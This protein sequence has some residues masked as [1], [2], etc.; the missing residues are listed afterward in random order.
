MIEQ[1]MQIDWLTTEADVLALEEAWDELLADSVMDTIFLSHAWAMCWWRHFGAG[2]TL[3]VLTVRDTDGRL[4]GLAP[5]VMGRGGWLGIWPARQLSL[6]GAEPTFADHLDVILRRGY[7]DS[8]GRALW[9]SLTNGD[10]TWDLMRIDGFSAASPMHALWGERAVSLSV[11]ACH[12]LTL[13]ATWTDYLDTLPAS[14][15]QRLGKRRRRLMK[16]DPEGAAFRT[17][18]QPDDLAPALE[19]LFRL[20]QENQQ[21]RGNAGSFAD[22]STRAF[23]H[24]VARRFLEKGW[25]RL[26]VITVG[27]EDIATAYC[28]QKNGTVSFFST[29]FSH[30]FTHHNPGRQILAHA[31]EKAIEDQATT[32][33]FLRGDESY[34]DSYSSTVRT[35]VHLCVAGHARARLLLGVQA[36]YKAARRMARPIKRA[37]KARLTQR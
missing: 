4:L 18:E 33:D 24:D 28:F 14:R 31:I 2:C 36:R 20:H 15:R 34:K 5:L 6:L 10:L 23:H 29:G 21:A 17:V 22:P 3:R 12:V 16:A 27:Q 30:R 13:P 37:V 7:E 11:S 25:L 1:T 35:N 19:S 26:H 8:A 32:F 9:A